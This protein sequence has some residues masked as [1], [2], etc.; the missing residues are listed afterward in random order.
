MSSVAEKW[1]L[2]PLVHYPERPERGEAWDERLEA[3]FAAFPRAARGIL[4]DAGARKLIRAVGAHESQHREMGDEALREAA[5]GLR[6]RLRREGLAA[7]A[8]VASFAL[9]RE[10]ARRRL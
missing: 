6:A 8:V 7:Q 4:S 3:A 5:D 10:V 1:R 9:I 2:P